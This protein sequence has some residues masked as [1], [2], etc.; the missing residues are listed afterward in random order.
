MLVIHSPFTGLTYIADLCTDD[1]LI[2]QSN[3][4]GW[5]PSAITAINGQEVTQFLS[6]FAAANAFGTLEAHSDWNQL[7]ASPAADIQGLP[8]AFTG[9]SPFYPGDT[10]EF[11]FENGSVVG[12]TP[13]LAL[14]NIPDE[15][16]IIN[17]GQDFFDFFVLGIFPT[18]EDDASQTAVPTAA[19]TAAAT[20]IFTFAASP[21]TAVPTT[22][23]SA[24]PT[25]DP[26]IDDP[27]LDDEEDEEPASWDNPG[28]PNNPDVIQPN[29]G[30]V[31]GG[32]LTGYFLNATSVGVLS[33]PNFELSPES[34]QSFSATVGEFL[35]RSKEAGLKN[36]V[37]DLQQNG[38]GDSLLATDTFKQFFPNIDPFGGN[39]L[40]AHPTADA[41]GNTFTT[42]FD[43]Q[44]M[45]GSF[46][47]AMAADVFTATDYINTDTGRNF[48]SW[49]EFFGPHPDHGDF[50]TTPVSNLSS[51]Y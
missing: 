15:T 25:D 17:T 18:S 4:T 6:Q 33:I 3:S 40:R 24:V 36:I 43:T 45:N 13:W 10:I 11:K 51:L 39:R 27:S 34:V 14:F 20:D 35:R 29:L 38:G 1:L 16:P 2:A 23:A 26:T 22:A 48:T 50:F 12:P 30:F 19:G 8:S 49:A 41:L 47:T 32:V 44:Q 28:Y 7:M 21:S 42:F 9:A 46:Y 5:T 31:N 37:I